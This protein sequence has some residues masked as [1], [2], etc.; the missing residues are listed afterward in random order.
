MWSQTYRNLDLQKRGVLKIE[1]LYTFLKIFPQ[2]PDRFSETCFLVQVQELSFT[3]KK[4]L[5]PLPCEKIAKSPEF[6]ENVHFSS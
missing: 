4:N 6:S 5:P 2:L 3:H 1:V